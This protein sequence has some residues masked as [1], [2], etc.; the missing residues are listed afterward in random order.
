V[1][2]LGILVILVLLENQD[3]LDTQDILVS[4]AGQDTLAI[5]VLVV[6]LATQVTQVS[7]AGLVIPGTLD[8]V[9]TR[10]ILV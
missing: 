8:L 6:G 2:G 9:V 3:I 1:V 5:L 4:V 10:V 7:V